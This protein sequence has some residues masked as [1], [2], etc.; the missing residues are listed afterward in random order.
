MKSQQTKSKL[1]ALAA[2][3]LYALNAPVSKILLG[4]IPPTIMA[5]LLYLGAG[6]GLFIVE[7]IQKKALGKTKEIPLSKAD[8]PYTVGMVALDVAAPVLMMTGLTMTSAANASL[9]NNFEIVATSVIAFCVF[10][11]KIS[12]RLW[13]G[14]ALVTIASAILSFEN[15]SSFKFSSGSVLVLLACCCWGLENNCT[16]KLSDKSPVQIV[17]IK[18]ICSGLCSLI[19]AL[20]KGERLSDFKYVPIAVLL[21]FTAYGLSIMFYIYAQR[22]LG[23][24]KTGAYYAAA[25]F[26]SSGLSLLIFGEIPSAP[27]AAALII[28]LAGAYYTSTDKNI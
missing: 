5:A 4:K 3:M 25:P 13:F 18:G 21:G 14:I 9:L 11:E 26:I 20:I 15:L 22:G 17:I 28:M 24:A 23:A 27:F 16:R 19:I 8:L 2:A 10:K 7:I 6:T 1:F 12:G